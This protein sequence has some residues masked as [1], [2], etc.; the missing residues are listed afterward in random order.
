[1]FKMR[2]EVIATDIDEVLFPFVETF[3][4]WHNQEYG[5]NLS[6]DD[7]NSYEFNDTLGVSVPETVHRVHQFLSMDHH[8]QGVEPLEHSMSAVAKLSEVYGLKA[9]TARRP[10]FEGTTSEYI[11]HYFERNIGEVTLVGTK[12]TMGEARSKA[13][14]CTELGAIALI[15]DSIEHVRGCAEVGVRG[16]LFGDYPWNRGDLLPDGVI[17]HTNWVGVLRHFGV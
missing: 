8:L 16:I 5:T 11:L 6:R 1:M 17:R 10:Q 9:V 3:S 13:E 7:F 4:G 12:A 15:D 14:V 2:K